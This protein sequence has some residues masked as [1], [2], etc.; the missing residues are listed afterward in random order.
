MGTTV[1]AT[2]LIAYLAERTGLQSWQIKVLRGVVIV[3]AFLGVGFFCVDFLEAGAEQQA[4]FDAAQLIRREDPR[5]TIWYAGYWGFQ[6]YAEKS[7]MKQI[8]PRRDIDG[9]TASLLP[10]SRLCS[11]DWLVIPDESVPQQE[12]DIDRPELEPQGELAVGDAVPL[13]TLMNY[14]AGTLPLRHQR[15][16]RIVLRLYRV[17][18]EFIAR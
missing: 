5:T 17:K 10:P 11:G 13:A 8:V 18:D 1:A 15:G 7:G 16:P 3:T 4:A 6:F 12:I 2:L 9:R 14:Y